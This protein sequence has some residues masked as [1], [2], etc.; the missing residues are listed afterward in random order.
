MSQY[1]KLSVAMERDFKILLIQPVAHIH[2]DLA[3]TGLAF[4]AGQTQKLDLELATKHVT[5]EG[6]W[7]Y[8][9]TLSR[10]TWT[11][12]FDFAP[13]FGGSASIEMTSGT[14]AELTFTLRLNGSDDILSSPV[15]FDTL[16]KIQTLSADDLVKNGA[17]YI[18]Q[19]DYI[20]VFA[21]S[22]SAA[23]YSLKSFQTVNNGR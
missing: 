1:E 14:T 5:A 6:G 18:S 16:N 10:F 15:T 9:N 8:D 23:T 3:I 13:I 4:T 2:L 12:D 19:N 7:V 17:P 11:K 21:T 22:D 20:E